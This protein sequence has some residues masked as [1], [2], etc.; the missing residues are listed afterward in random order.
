MDEDKPC[1]KKG[2]RN[3]KKIHTTIV[4]YNAVDSRLQNIFIIRIFDQYP[5]SDAMFHPCIFDGDGK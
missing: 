1:E 5:D 4:N 2:A 3:H